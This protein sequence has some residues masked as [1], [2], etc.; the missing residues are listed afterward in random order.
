VSVR[1]CRGPGHLL[2]DP[3]YVVRL[4]LFAHTVDQKSSGYCPVTHLSAPGNYLCPELLE[5]AVE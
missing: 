5:L 4:R 2:V 1:H 3:R